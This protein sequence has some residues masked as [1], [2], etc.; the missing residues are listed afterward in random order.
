MPR[1]LMDPIRRRF[2]AVPRSPLRSLSD[3]DSLRALARNLREG[4]YITTP[5]GEILDGNPALAEMFGVQS[6]DEL[7][8]HTV[9]ELLLDPARREEERALLE[10]DGAVRDFEFWIVRPRDGQLR[11]VLDTAYLCRDKATGETFYHG[12]LIDITRRKELEMQLLDQAQRDPLTG[13]YNRRYL[14]QLERR[15][16][17]DDVS[18]W[19]CIYIDVDHFKRYND[20]HGH[21][22]GDQVLV[23]M[24]R[25]LMSQVRAEEVV[26]RVG[27][28]E[29]LVFLAGADEERT[30]NVAARLQSAALHIAPVPF[31]L[32]WASRQE[33]EALE[34]TIT[35]ADHG[36]LT[37][38]VV[39]RSPDMQRR[40]E[41]IE[42]AN[43]GPAGD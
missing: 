34:K 30:R 18:R 40:R 17:A 27:G 13:C 4:I 38:R 1:R 12:V 23:R 24:A 37:V 36:L 19:G 32:G 35:R 14:A 6:L 43:G 16:E 20:R 26:V 7:R 28:D 8:Q 9:E 5:E 42:L 11:A 22:A 2:R 21:D 33:G 39:E 3:P 29:F 10:R 15:L 41:Q 25:Y 31:S